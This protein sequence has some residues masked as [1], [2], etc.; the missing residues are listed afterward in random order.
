[1]DN[2]T[3]ILR[4]FVFVF[5]YIFGIWFYLSEFIMSLE[6]AKRI[7]QLIS[8]DST[9]EIKRLL[10]PYSLEQR[11]FIMS[12]DVGGS[13]FLFYAVLHQSLA[14][15]IY[16]L[17]ECGADPNSFGTEE[18]GKRTCLSKAVSLD[19]MFMV[20]ILLARGA[21]ING[22]SF[23]CETAIATACF[24][25]NLEMIKFLVENGANITIQIN[26]EN[27]SLLPTYCNCDI[28]KYLITKGANINMMDS[29]GTTILM[30][31]VVNSNREILSFL[32]SRQDIDMRLKNQYEED[33]LNLAMCF[34]SDDITETIIRHGGYT[35]EEVIGKYVLESYFEYISRRPSKSNQLWQKSLRLRDLPMDTPIFNNLLPKKT[36]N[37]ISLFR[38]YD[39]QALLHMR[40]IYG[41]R[42]VNTLRATAIALRFV[43]DRQNFLEIYESFSKILHSLNCKVFLKI[44]AHIE[45]LLGDYISYFSEEAASLEEFFKLLCEYTL[46]FRAKYQQPMSPSIRN[47]YTTKLY[48]FIDYIIE[49]IPFLI[50]KYKNSIHI[51]FTEIK[52]FIKIHVE[53]ST[54]GSFAWM[55]LKKENFCIFGIFLSCGANVN[56]TDDNNET[57]LH[58]LLDSNISRKKRLIKLV[59]DAGFDFSRVTST[60]YC[61]PC[62]MKKEDIFFLPRRM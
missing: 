35:K 62:R 22:V 1:M 44:N 50:K 56:E 59:V 52:K 36:D 9:N 14:V 47:L 29:E 53:N 34:C 4:L 19:S 32:L 39:R 25:N 31:A 10:S 21:D 3:V 15:L 23:G 27:N 46:I 12:T 16:F 60:K 11:R 51:I 17:D 48:D 37:D 33:A 6:I 41:S 28:L 57:I 45:R 38:E 55:C 13:S 2:R 7:A 20:E 61:L 43:N 8:S 5:E 54:S 40:T 26:N 18:Y 24:M 58:Y 49:L 30:Q 42:H